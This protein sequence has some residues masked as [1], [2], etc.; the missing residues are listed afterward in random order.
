MLKTPEKDQKN[1]I[2]KTNSLIQL[3]SGKKFE[4]FNQTSR[5]IS[6]VKM[7]LL[8]TIQNPNYI[9]ECSD[10]NNSSVKSKLNILRILFFLF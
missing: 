5:P 2:Y 10:N 1:E 8:Q 7:N 6:P 3:S 4:N 9:T